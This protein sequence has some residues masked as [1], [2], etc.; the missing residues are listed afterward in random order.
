MREILLKMREKM[1]QPKM[2]TFYCIFA[3]FRGGL[4][5]DCFKIIL[6]FKFYFILL[7]KIWQKS[8]CATFFVSRALREFEKSM[9]KKQKKWRVLTF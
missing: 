8:K 9:R 3:R 1:R 7:H 5:F 4:V 6:K 2:S